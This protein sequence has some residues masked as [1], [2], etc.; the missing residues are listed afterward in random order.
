MLFYGGLVA[1]V[2]AIVA[3]LVYAVAYV[4]HVDLALVAQTRREGAATKK[5]FD[6][7][8][9][10]RTPEGFH[11]KDMAEWCVA[12]QQANRASGIT[13]PDPYTLPGYRQPP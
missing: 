3:M 7:L 12:F 11:R 8:V 2:V 13:C 4:R 6:T 9:V 10:G 5:A 1:M